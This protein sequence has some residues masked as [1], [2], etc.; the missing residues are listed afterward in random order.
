MLLLHVHPIGSDHWNEQA[1]IPSA[2]SRLR[3]DAATLGQHQQ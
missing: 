2:R 1:T 3:I